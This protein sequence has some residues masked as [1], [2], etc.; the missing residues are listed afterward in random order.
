MINVW[1]IRKWKQRQGDQE[2]GMTTGQT[3]KRCEINKK[4]QKKIKIQQG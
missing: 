4:G 2:K 3:N 1:K